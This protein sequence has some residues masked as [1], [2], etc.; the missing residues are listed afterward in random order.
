MPSAPRVG[1]ESQQGRAMAVLLCSRAE[2]VNVPAERT[3]VLSKE[4][5]REVVELTE[6]ADEGGSWV[7]PAMGSS[8]ASG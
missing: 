2:T 7:A 1:V 5:S 6:A 3:S 8:L 4:V